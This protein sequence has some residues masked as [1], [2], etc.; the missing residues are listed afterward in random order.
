MNLLIKWGC[1]GGGVGLLFLCLCVSLIAVQSCSPLLTSTV[2]YPDDNDPDTAT[3]D[4]A[5]EVYP[6]NPFYGWPITPG[7]PVN[8]H[9]CSGIYYQEFGRTHWGIDIN[10]YRGEPVY[11]TAHGVIAWAYYDYTYGMGRTVKVCHATGWC[12]IYMHLDGFAVT[13]GDTVAPG[14]T[15]GYADS[16][17]FSSGDHLHYQINRPGGAP[18]NPYPTLP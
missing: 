10:A 2:D 1:G 18:V 3:C 5:A 17:G 12:A 6:D 8:Y 7:N 4:N 15:L 14:M 11:A 13:Q 16:T 9:Y